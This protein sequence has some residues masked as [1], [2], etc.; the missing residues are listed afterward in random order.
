MHNRYKCQ[1]GKDRRFNMDLISVI[2]PVY[3]VELFLDTCIESVVNQTYKN[4][5]VI[6][7]E[8]GSPDRCSELCDNWAVKDN[9]IKVIHVKNGGAGKARNIALENATGNII[10]F[11]DSDDYLSP[12]MFEYLYGLLA[13]DIDVVECG[14]VQVYDNLAF[15][16]D[17]IGQFEVEYFTSEEALRENIRDTKFRQL[18][19][20]KLY[21]KE[22]VENIFFPVGKKI[23]DE[24]WTYQVLGNAKNLIHSDIKLYAYRQQFDSV[25]HCL[26]A[27]KRL[28]AI[29]AK[30]KR[31]DYIVEKYPKL[32]NESLKNLW[33]T[34]MY[35][36]QL[37]LQSKK[38]TFDEQA[39]QYIKNVL[40]KYPINIKKQNDFSAKEKIWLMIAKV[41]FVIVCRL[42]NILGVGI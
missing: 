23:D 1:F 21:R 28:Q 13:E 38:N 15:F 2:I 32:C 40:Y 11:V 17:N 6:L 14:Y 18:I 4:L 33:F 42:R 39:M 34:C 29:E 24:F 20:N 10:A 27:D 22:I 19:W 16:D 30:M 25:M 35:Q 36:G 26:T 41:S 7:V 31:H 12:Y 5:E 37:I 3:K 8:D 9:R